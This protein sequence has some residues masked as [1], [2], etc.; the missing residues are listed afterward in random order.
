MASP[1]APLPIVGRALLVSNDSVTARQL[2]LG[3][4]HF[5]MTADVC[6]D[7]ATAVGLINTRKFEA[8]VVDC[9]FGEQVAQVLERVR[10][11]PSNQNAVTFALVNSS[12]R[13][14]PGV[15]TN[16]VMEKPLD[17]GAVER[18]MKVALG[19]IIREYRRYVRCPVTVP[20]AIQLENAEGLVCQTL[21]ISEGGMSIHTSMALKPGA[22]ARVRFVLPGGPAAFDLETE[23]C[24]CD[25][26]GRAGLHFD[27]VPLEQQAIL[28]GW[29]SRK[30]EQ[31]LP[32][33][34]AKLFQ[35]R[36]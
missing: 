4:E 28:Q 27:S 12:E 8:I 23:I 30:I 1:G 2:A 21:N 6:A 22:G 7:P 10:V 18:T 3:M 14:N 35:K 34:V 9:T 32:D 13:R 5:A 29:L 17:D 36:E 25:N 26:K 11:S 16:F 31:V 20:V 19:L 15:E 24:W 33:T